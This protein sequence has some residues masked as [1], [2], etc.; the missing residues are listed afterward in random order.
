MWY[1]PDEQILGFQFC[2]DRSSAEKALTWLPAP[3]FSHN[4]IDGGKTDALAYRHP[5]MVSSKP[6]TATT[7]LTQR[8]NTVAG[9]LPEAIASFVR[10][11]L[12]EFEQRGNQA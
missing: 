6:V 11:K 9:N 4:Y 1:T 5:A 2:Y 10:A 7:A 8:F 3:G 12:A